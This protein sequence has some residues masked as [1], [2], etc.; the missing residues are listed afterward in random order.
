MRNTST[1]ESME[2]ENMMGQ[3]AQDWNTGET[4]VETRENHS[5]DHSDVFEREGVQWT[6]HTEHALAMDRTNIN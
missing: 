1:V 2:L 4:R 6:K 3:A 5:H